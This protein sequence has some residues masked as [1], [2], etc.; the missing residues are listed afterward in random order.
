M[1][2]APRFS[3]PQFPTATRTQDATESP[4]TLFGTLPRRR[5]GVGALWSHQVD[6]LRDNVN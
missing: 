2:D 1:T 6:Q 4:E 5:D 3:R